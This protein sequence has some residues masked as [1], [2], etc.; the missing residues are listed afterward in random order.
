MHAS[1]FEVLMYFLEAYSFS[2]IMVPSTFPKAQ[3]LWYL[4]NVY[5]YTTLGCASY[6]CNK[7]IVIVSHAILKPS[8]LFSSTIFLFYIYIYI[9]EN[10]ND[11]QPNPHSRHI[12]CENSV[13]ISTMIINDV[14]TSKILM[15]KFK[16]RLND[17]SNHSLNFKSSFF[18]FV[19]NTIQ[20][21]IPNNFWG[22]LHEGI[23]I[24]IL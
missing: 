17:T 6:I 10:K 15:L 23:P 22:T 7:S 9:C 16:H 13:I 21:G 8:N 11:E 24:G 3:K 1:H 19:P 2:Y 20:R 12:Q 18:H 14:Q 5:W 4:H